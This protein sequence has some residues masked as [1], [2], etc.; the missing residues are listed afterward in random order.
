MNEWKKWR[1]KE[2]RWED[3]NRARAE[4]EIVKFYEE[5]ERD[6]EKTLIHFYD[7]MQGAHHPQAIPCFESK[8]WASFLHEIV[9]RGIPEKK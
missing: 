1:E 5:N 2:E 4:Q 6:Y 9:S 3:E 7:R 8:R